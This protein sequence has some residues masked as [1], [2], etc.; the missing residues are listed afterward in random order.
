MVHIGR[1][2]RD[3][4]EDEPELTWNRQMPELIQEMVHKN[5]TAP[6][7]GIADEKIAG[8]EKRYDA[9]VQTARKNMKRLPHPIITVTGAICICGCW[10][11][12]IIICCSCQIPW[13]LR[14][15]ICANE[16][17]GY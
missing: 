14:I 11:T 8:L 13:W 15:I 10:N 9:I 7:E 5:N 16:R 4:M 17:R 3:S 1:Y 12:G 6:E 2:L